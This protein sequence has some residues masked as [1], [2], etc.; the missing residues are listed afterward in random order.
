M[1]NQRNLFQT[2]SVSTE[3]DSPTASPSDTA[4][5]LKTYSIPD[6][7]SRCPI[8]AASVALETEAGKK[9]FKGDG[10]GESD[11]YVMKKC[12]RPC[13]D[14]GCKFK[15]EVTQ[16]P[17][18]I[19]HLRPSEQNAAYGA[20]LSRAPIHKVPEYYMLHLSRL[21]EIHG[22]IA[23]AQVDYHT[24]VRE[25]DDE[26]RPMVADR[27][28]REDEQVKETSLAYAR[29]IKHKENLKACERGIRRLLERCIETFEGEE[30]QYKRS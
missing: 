30:L 17:I 13:Y 20:I 9:N 4:L 2:T 1:H 8:L 29:A 3:L 23:N 12:Y 19:T 7:L 22:D 21:H 16:I 5:D 14:E 10:E 6:P 18:L 28:Y 25:R 24:F 11:K 15:I 26:R 27:E